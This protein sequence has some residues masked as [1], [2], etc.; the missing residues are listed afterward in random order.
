MAIDKYTA[1]SLELT[2]ACFVLPS[3]IGFEAVPQATAFR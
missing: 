3:N 1:H 2:N